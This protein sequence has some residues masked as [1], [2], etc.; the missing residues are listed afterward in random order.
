MTPRRPVFT[1]VQLDRSLFR[2]SREPGPF[3]WLDWAFAGPDN[4]FGSRW[5]DAEGRYRVLYASSQRLGCFLE[6]LDVF[7]PDPA[8]AAAYAEM[9]VDDDEA[10]EPLGTLPR[11]WF[12]GRV[13]AKAVAAEICGVFVVIGAAR[14]IATLRRV[15]GKRAAE[16][17]LPDLD[18][19]AIRL[20]APRAFTQ[21]V[22]SYVARQSDRDGR[23][24]AGIQYDSRHGDEIENWA[25]FEQESMNGRSPVLCVEAAPIDEADADLCT[26][27]EMLGLRLGGE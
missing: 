18:A 23:P 15:L 19:A 2:I 16:H 17:G 20:K 9:A 5:D 4:T 13:V 21:A 10:T 14:T 12:A 3:D 1:T 6:T 26:A 25:I 24:Y 8:I 7:R 22:S 11:S 27:L